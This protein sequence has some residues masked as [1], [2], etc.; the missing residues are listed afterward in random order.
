MRLEI[1]RKS[2]LA[3][4]ALLYLSRTKERTK[5]SVLADAIGTTPGFLSQAMTPLVS[6]G[7][8]RSEPGPTGGYTALVNTAEISVLD[9]IETVEGPTDTGRCVLQDRACGADNPCALHRPWSN[10]RAHLLQDLAATPVATLL[11]GLER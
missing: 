6:A 7:W 11:T 8:V 9:V 10:A 2:D 4:Q 1:T 5:A 3:T